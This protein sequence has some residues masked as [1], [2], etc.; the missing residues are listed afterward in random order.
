MKKKKNELADKIISQ[1]KYIK[2]ELLK[3]AANNPRRISA[4]KLKKLCE[5]IKTNPFFFELRPI[6]A[7]NKTGENIVIAGNQRLLASK[8]LGLDKVPAIIANLTKEQEEKVMIWDNVSS[9]DFHLDELQTF[10]QELLAATGLDELFKQTEEKVK[11]DTV[12]KDMEAQAFEIYDYVVIVFNNT[13][14]WLNFTQ[15]V[16]LENVNHSLIKTKK[17]GLG[18]VLNGEKFLERFEYK[19]DNNKPK[20]V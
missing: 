11:D 4:E 13:F 9:G 6:I 10:P 2:I 14:N 20:S 8:Q 5:N 16:G 3:E 18:R 15:K 1:A 19:D 7:N 12:Y 17:I